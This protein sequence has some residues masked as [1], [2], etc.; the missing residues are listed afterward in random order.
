MEPT[1]GVISRPRWG[2]QAALQR[3][4]SGFEVSVFELEDVADVVYREPVVG[5]DGGGGG[6]GGGRG[7]GSERF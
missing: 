1:I 2:P 7:G 6:G 4:A 3:S 5:G